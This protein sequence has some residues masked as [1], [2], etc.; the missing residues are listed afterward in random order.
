MVIPALITFL[1]AI[2]ALLLQ[3]LPP[4]TKDPYADQPNTFK[5]W[6]TEPQSDYGCSGWL[7]ILTLL[8]TSF[9]FVIQRKALVWGAAALSAL[10]LVSVLGLV[11]KQWLQRKIEAK[12]LARIELKK[13]SIFIYGLDGQLVNEAKFADIIDL[14]MYQGVD[15]TR[16]HYEHRVLKCR[17]GAEIM[18]PPHIQNKSQLRRMIQEA[19]NLKFSYRNNTT[20]P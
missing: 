20:R 14:P 17:S 2:F 15:Q 5:V 10:C 9:G 6:Q 13:D 1:W 16:K 12:S 4:R 8:A 18:L 7:L 3:Y 19:T 11:V